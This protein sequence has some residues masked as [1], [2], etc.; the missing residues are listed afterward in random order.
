M[1]SL[2]TTNKFRPTARFWI[3]IGLLAASGVAMAFIVAFG[4]SESKAFTVVWTICVADVYLIAS[5]AARHRWLRFAIWVGTAIV[6]VGGVIIAFIPQEEQY[7][8]TA[9]STAGSWE[10]ERTP[11]GVFVETVYSLHVLVIVLVLLGF[12]SLGYRFVCHERVLWVI[13][14]LTFITALAAALLITFDLAVQPS[15]DFYAGQVS[16]SILAFTGAAIVIIGALVQRKA[17][18]A[19]P[20]QTVTQSS[21]PAGAGAIVVDHDEL[22]A[23]VRTII[24]EEL[25]KGAGSEGD[26]HGGE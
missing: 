23:L 26:A 9:T 3:L 15:A 24:A 16:L 5:L 8:E 18:Q 2:T 12:V 17:G 11:Y 7:R 25:A 14:I 6:F 4:L 22:R 20:V 21:F 1:T 19:G 13:Y 10:W